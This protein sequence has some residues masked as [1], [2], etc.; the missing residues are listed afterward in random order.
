[1]LAWNPIAMRCTRVD[2]GCRNCWHLATC[3]RFV[4]NPVMEKLH[5]AYSGGDAVWCENRVH[6]DGH[7]GGDAKI[8][9]VQFMGDL[10]HEKISSTLRNG[11]LSI[12]EINP[13][14]TFLL[15]TKRPQNVTEELPG[16]C[17]LGTSVSNQASADTRIPHL[18][19][20]KCRHRW[21]SIEPILGE[22]DLRLGQIFNGTEE[23]DFFSDSI[24]W[25]AAGP[26]TG[27]G[28]R[29]YENRW[30]RLL[31]RTCYTASIPF[32]DKRDPS[33]LGFTRREWPKEWKKEQEDKNESVRT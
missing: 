6:P 2:E 4:K 7:F 25:V 10:W 24:K 33:S 3:D 21:L 30:M 12:I 32:Y 11:V 17:W 29:Q 14:N 19:A 15:L 20:A 26:E 1:V 5:G 22:V 13:A 27:S 18:L 28:A 23:K 9:A 31:K 16:N 8:I